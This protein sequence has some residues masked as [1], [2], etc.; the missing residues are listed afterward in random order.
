M[1]KQIVCGE[2]SRQAIVLCVDEKSQIA[3][4]LFRA[5]MSKNCWK[6]EGHASSLEQTTN[7]HAGEGRC[8]R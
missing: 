8:C 6:K 2:D 1:A 7:N 5:V 3:R 4:F